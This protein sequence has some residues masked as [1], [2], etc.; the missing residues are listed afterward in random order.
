MLQPIL[1]F[2]LYSHVSHSS[3]KKQLAYILA[4]Q[5]FHGVDEDL[6]DDEVLTEILGN[7]KL[8]EHFQYFGKELNLVEPR[9]LEDIY[10]SHLEN[11]RAG[12]S[13][14]AVDSAKQNLA[15]TFVNAFVN[16]GFGNDKLMAKAEE[17]QSWIYKN[18]DHG[19]LSAAAS[20]GLSFLWNPESGLDAIDT[21][22]YA[23][24][25]YIKA[26]AMLANGIVQ[27]G[28]KSEA[29]AAYA[30]LDEHIDS[31]SVPVRTSAI[32]G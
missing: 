23:S 12:A 5:Q 24:E 29:D 10:K 8:S 32:M 7:V 16:V 14:A 17:G 13:A 2:S 15:G 18:K 6:A 27:S 1:L 9:S 19:M 25:E 11:T 22:T 3:M 26:G 21:Y 20:L 4:R 28:L 30:L 31:N